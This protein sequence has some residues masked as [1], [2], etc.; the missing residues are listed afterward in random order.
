VG[1]EGCFSL[2]LK[3]QEVLL[4]PLGAMYLPE[5][6]T[7]LVADLHF[8]KGSAFACRTG[9]LLPPYDTGEI[10]DRLEALLA[11]FEPQCFVSLGDSFHDG[12]AMRR[13]PQACID[14]L[15]GLVSLVPEWVWI[16]GNHDPLP[17]NVA[18]RVVEEMS[19]SPFLLRH[20]PVETTPLYQLCGHY[21]PKARV[22]IRGMRMAA[23]CFLVGQRH[24]LFPAFGAYTGGLD[25]SHEALQPYTASGFSL[26][27]CT[28]Q[29]VYGM[30]AENY[31]KYR[32]T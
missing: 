30:S 24:C 19:L 29:A 14:R 27:L 4:H 22:K 32:V 28:R 1:R 9:Q 16:T 2:T 20:D 6:G 15:N 31:K 17:Q 26:Y 7:L 3:G 11:I 13:M 12:E 18:G 25:V 8:E 10:L 5:S 23:P 21:H